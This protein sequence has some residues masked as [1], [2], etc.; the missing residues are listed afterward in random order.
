MSTY[1]F[2][3]AAPE[4][5]DRFDSLE[6]CYDTVTTGR[7]ESL[8]I[9]SGWDCLEVGGGGGSIARWLSQRVGPQGSVLATDIHPDRMYGAS[10]NLEI[11]RH[12]IVTDDLPTEHFDLVHA[13]LVLIHIPERH[14][15]VRRILS[16]LKPGGV[17][18][19]DE[20]D[21][22][23]RMPALA[24]PSPAAANLIDKV[25][26]GVHQL[27]E[28]AGMDSAWARTAYQT[29]RDTG[30]VDLGFSGFCEPWEGGSPGAH[31]H[32]ANAQQVSGQ[33]LAEGFA[34]EPE[35]QEFLRLLDQPELTLSSYLMLSTWGRRPA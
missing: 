20:F 12:N 3:N 5:S 28:R 22:T 35:L 8:G 13:R 32:R 14:R 31:L 15:V 6:H 18:L 25:I 21:L 23:W 19:L 10:G 33:L 34:S 17:L 9:T 2:D 30:F 4:A 29:L 27:L 24:A 26:S 7:L 1:L 16:S 11:R